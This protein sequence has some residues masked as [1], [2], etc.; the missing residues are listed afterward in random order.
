MKFP[1]RHRF[2]APAGRPARGHGH[3]PHHGHPGEHGDR[4]HHGGHGEHRRR[5]RVFESGDVRLL[6]LYI[7]H[8]QDSHGY[9]VIRA[10]GELVGGDYQ[11]SPG[12]IYPTLTLLEDLGHAQAQ[13]EAGRK[14]YAITDIG[15]AELQAQD[16]LLQALLGKLQHLRQRHAGHRPPEL[17]RAM[18]NL[19]SAMRLRIDRTGPD[20]DLVQ[21]IAAVIDRAAQDIERL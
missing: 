11:P 18:D 5:E 7:L 1:F 12:T 6:V 2:E 19:K 4:G 3:H 13:E 17:L 9:E 16:A 14:R 21:R 15:R 20:Q 8:G 10:I